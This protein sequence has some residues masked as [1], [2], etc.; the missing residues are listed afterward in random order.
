MAKLTSLVF[1]VSAAV[2]LSETVFVLGFSSI[3]TPKTTGRPLTP[4][5]YRCERSMS[6]RGRSQFREK[7]VYPLFSSPD[8][9]L[10]PDES[11]VPADEASE[12][13]EEG[14][15]E[16]KSLV[17]KIRAY[18]TPPDDGLSFRQRLAKM[19]LAVALSYG[20]VSNMSYTVTVSLAWF[21][22][23]K[24]VSPW[25][26]LILLLKICAAC[27]AG[28]EILSLNSSVVSISSDWQKSASTGTMER[29]SGRLWWFLG[30]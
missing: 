24:N 1:L 20:W 16:K 28:F 25:S 22:F 19:G 7:Q 6:P 10:T 5:F 27:I 21:I 9:S 18:F 12:A 8:E 11:S 2:W 15:Q 17:Q 26:Y 4:L 13:I 14:G 29:F 23:S 30:L 3:L